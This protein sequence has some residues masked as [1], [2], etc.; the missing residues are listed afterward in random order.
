MTDTASLPSLSTDPVADPDAVLQGDTWRITVLTDG[1]LRLEHAADGRFE[2][3]ASTFAL[4]RRLPVPDFRVTDTGTHL[5]VTTDRLRLTYDKGPFSTSGL[6]VEVLGGITTYHSVWRYG[7]PAPNLGGTARTL[8]WAD[9]AVPLEPGV[10]A[11]EGFAVL[12]DSASLLWDADGWVAPRDGSRTDL[13]VFAYGR[14]HAE[15]VRAFHAVS[16]PAPVLPRWALGNWWSRYH[17]YTAQEYEALLDRFTQEGIPFSVAVLDMDWHLRDVDPQ[18]GS[19]WTGYTWNRDLVPDPPEF[20][21]RVHARGLRVTLNVHPADGVQPYEDAYPAMAA[22]LGRD[23]AEQEP[24]AFDVTDRAFLAAYFHVLHRGLEAD[25]VDFWWIDWQSG[26]YSRLAGIDPL[27][28]LNHFHYLDNAHDGRRPLTFSRYAGPGS[29][30]YPIGFSGDTV[31]SWAS[32][33]FE[34]HFT[35]TAANIGYGWWSHDIGGHFFGTKDDELA[36]RWVQLG[37]FSP[38]LRLHSSNDPFTTKEPWSFG[39]LARSIQT[40]FLRLRHRLVPYLHTMNHR[41]A[42]DAVPLVVP[43]YHVWPNDDQAYGHPTQFVFGSELLVAA[44]TS[45]VD[46]R[47]L[48]GSVRAW[49][50]AGTWVDLLSDLGYD[51]GREIVLHRDLS[52]IPVLARTGAI[53]PLDGAH[54]PAGDPVNPEHLEVLVVVGADGAFELVEDDGTGDGLDPATVV[55]TPIGYEQACGRVSVGPA[56]GALTALPPSRAWTLTLVGTDAPGQPSASVDGAPVPVEVSRTPTRTSVTVA[57][58]PSGSALVVELGG[59]PALIANDVR[60]RLY[61]LLDAA[62]IEYQLKT[63]ILGIA[64]SQAPLHVRVSHLHA[65]GLEPA[66]ASAVDEILLARPPASP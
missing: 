47:T 62:Q 57:G 7:Q 38:I 54:V 22:A 32:L 1:L 66:L 50:P 3:R 46:R 36:T 26:P 51:G 24:I 52:A 9:G 48:T 23:P 25:G 33:E 65:L 28:M 29:H 43:L 35:A 59:P 42:R 45:P 40:R 58:V 39:P 31:I 55:R 37:V 20:L 4:H 60:G 61:G 49:L 13:Y 6:A 56:G 16:G 44:I 10:V 2:D 21:R 64:T 5:V 15:A 8:D 34:P 14:D 17:P 27:W 63:Q 18:Y 12:D 19:G 11:R 53:V 41:A 30:R